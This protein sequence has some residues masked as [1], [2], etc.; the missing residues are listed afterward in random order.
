MEG[1]IIIAKKRKKS[2]VCLSC[3]YKY[4]DEWHKEHPPLNE[5]NKIDV[6]LAKEYCE[7]QLRIYTHKNCKPVWCDE[8]QNL[9][10]YL[11]NY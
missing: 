7:Y 6:K 1:K 9:K 2:K 11:I 4:N 3:G 5:N 8:C 10:E